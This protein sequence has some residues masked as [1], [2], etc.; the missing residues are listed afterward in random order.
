MPI[1]RWMNGYRAAMKAAKPA[2]FDEWLRREPEGMTEFGRAQWFAGWHSV[3]K[4]ERAA[5]VESFFVD[6]ARNGGGE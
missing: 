3:W 5:E 2:D 4:C 1:N 6:N